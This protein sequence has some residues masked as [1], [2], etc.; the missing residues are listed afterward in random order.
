M[1]LRY[2]AVC[3][4]MDGTLLDTRV[5]YAKMANLVFD[6]MVKIGVPEDAINREDGYKFNLDSGVNY[7][8]KHGREKELNL[9]YDNIK[10]TARN[11]E[12]ENVNEAKPFKGAAELLDKLHTYGI[13]TGVLTRGCREYAETALGLSGVLDRLDVLIARDDYPENEAKPSPIAMTHMAEKLGVDAKDILFFG[14]HLFDYQC[15][16]SAG[17]GFIGVLS[18]AYKRS[19]WEKNGMKDILD[20][21]SDFDCDTIIL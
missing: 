19:D 21:I 2:K 7:L 4:D 15:A 6:E 10:N 13:K 9:V 17:A 11:V 16:S 14:D 20:S 1:D 12:M 3:F 18:G 8:R 5:D